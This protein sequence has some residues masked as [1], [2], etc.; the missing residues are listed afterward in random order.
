[1]LS[2]ET[3][4]GSGFRGLSPSFCS[5]LRRE[6]EEGGEQ[7]SPCHL[8]LSFMRSWRRLRH[9]LSCQGS[10]LETIIYL[11]LGIRC[12]EAV[13]IRNKEIVPFSVST[14]VLDQGQFCPPFP[15]QTFGNVW[16]RHF[17]CHTLR[18]NGLLLASTGLRPGMLVASFNAQDRPR[19]KELF[20]CG[21]YDNRISSNNTTK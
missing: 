6:L 7:C 3:Q 5:R 16:R 12:L 13:P 14:V 21:Y 19:N 10:M 4:I 15:P 18:G 1:M 9:G 11:I 8:P 17:G 20:L 2:E